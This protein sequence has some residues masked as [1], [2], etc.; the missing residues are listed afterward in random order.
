M[1]RESSI[2]FGYDLN[3]GSIADD[4][5]DSGVPGGN[6]ILRF[7]DAVM[8]GTESDQRA[9]RSSIVDELGPESLIDAAGVFG[10]F[11]MMNRVAEGTGIPVPGAAIERE[12]QMVETLGLNS[13]YKH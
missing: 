9:A 5:I 11:Q 1:L 4:S 7:V 13:F 6:M 8:S 12:A 2:T 10:N 3:I